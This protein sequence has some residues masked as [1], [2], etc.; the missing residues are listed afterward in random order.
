MN[1]SFIFHHTLCFHCIIS[2]LIVWLPN[3]H[4]KVKSVKLGGQSIRPT[5][6]EAKGGSYGQ[7]FH[8]GKWA[9][10]QYD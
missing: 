9:S 8:G 5:G 1:S 6:V 10:S 3:G 7:S 2:I 4:G